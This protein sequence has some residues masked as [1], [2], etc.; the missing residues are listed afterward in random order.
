MLELPRIRDSPA[1][2]A[3]AWD[4]YAHYYP[5]PPHA[6]AFLL[7]SGLPLTPPQL[8]AV[9][10]G[11]L[12]AVGCPYAGQIRSHSLRR[13]GAQA[14]QSAGCERSD[15]A[16]HGTWKSDSGLKAYVPKSASRAVANKLSQLFA[17]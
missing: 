6:P 2:P 14:A 9:M 8:V 16:H 10:K 1:C 12:F 4:M 15:I 11:A 7:S 5:A 13:G 17:H 3:L